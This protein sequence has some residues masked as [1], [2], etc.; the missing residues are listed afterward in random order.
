MN[1]AASAR[2]RASINVEFRLG[3][4]RPGAFRSVVNVETVGDESHADT[5][6]GNYLALSQP[7]VTRLVN[8]QKRAVSSKQ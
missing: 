1:G 4:F 8:K 5:P 3:V 7:S 2:P 6:G